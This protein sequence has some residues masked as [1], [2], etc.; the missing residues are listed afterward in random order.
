MECTKEHRYNDAFNNLARD[1]GGR[2]KCVGYAYDLGYQVGLNQRER[3]HIDLDNLPNS[4]AGLVRH[5]SPYAAYAQ[6]YLDG[7][8]ESYN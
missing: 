8:H 4:Q 6:G 1:Q 3:L 5:K 2:H 7:V